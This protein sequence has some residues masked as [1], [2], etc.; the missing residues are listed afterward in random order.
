M[1]EWIAI[2]L[3][4]AAGVWG[5]ER[6][7]AHGRR[8]PVLDALVDAVLG[9]DIRVLLVILACVLVA[10]VLLA[11]QASPALTLIV[12]GVATVV[13]L[14]DRLLRRRGEG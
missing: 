9:L 13:F 4:A 3:L 2:A 8:I 14:L 5:W 6:V 10:G 1:I 7:E 11:V 12:T